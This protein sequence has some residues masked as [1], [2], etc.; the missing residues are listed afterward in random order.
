MNPMGYIASKQFIL[1]PPLN[2]K[3]FPVHRPSGL[4]WADWIFL[5]IYLFIYFFQ[6]FR[7]FF[8]LNPLYILVYKE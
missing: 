8:L 3:L 2:K 6:I 4:K 7:F 5:F 1:R